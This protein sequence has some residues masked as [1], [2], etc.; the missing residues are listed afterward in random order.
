MHQLFVLNNIPSRMHGR[1]NA[2]FKLRDSVPH[3]RFAHPAATSRTTRRVNNNLNVCL[4][5]DLLSGEVFRELVDLRCGAGKEGALLMN[6]HGYHLQ[7]ALVRQWT[8][9]RQPPRLYPPTS[10]RPV[11]S[12]LTRAE[13]S[14]WNVSV[15]YAGRQKRGGREKPAP[16][17][18]PWA[19]PHTA[20]APCPVAPASRAGR[21]RSLRTAACDGSHPPARLRRRSPPH[22]PVFNRGVVPP[23]RHLSRPVAG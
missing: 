10:H 22:S 16:R 9:M 18:T 20:D 13:A 15:M 7:H 23:T 6:A 17:Y 14:F 2:A 21:A 8:P 1:R 19:P 11:S 12:S 3:T 5:L 4:R